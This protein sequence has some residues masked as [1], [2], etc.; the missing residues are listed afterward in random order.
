MKSSL[1][2]I[3]L[4]SL[5]LAAGYPPIS[6]ED[7]TGQLIAEAPPG[8]DMCVTRVQTSPEATDRDRFA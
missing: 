1:Y 7:P 4:A 6:E 3:V 2:L 5:S 8:F